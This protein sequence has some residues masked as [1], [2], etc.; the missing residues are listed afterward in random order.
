MEALP[1][2]LSPYARD[3]GLLSQEPNT[4]ALIT[5]TVE[6]EYGYDDGIWAVSI[7]FPNGWVITAFTDDLHLIRGEQVEDG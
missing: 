3:G 4:W 5:P 2:Q 7:K 6:G 1:E